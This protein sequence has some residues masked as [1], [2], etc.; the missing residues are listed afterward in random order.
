MIFSI[1]IILNKINGKSYIGFTNNINKRFREHKRLYKTSNFP[2]YRA[3]RKYTI[4]NFEFSIIYQSKDKEHTLCCMESYFIEKYNAFTEGY[5]CTLGGEGM[6]GHIPWNK[7]IKTGSQ[8]HETKQKK[9]ETQKKIISRMTPEIRKVKY[10]SKKEKNGMFGKTHSDIAK[11]KQRS[12]NIKYNYEV[13]LNSG[14]IL[15]T[16]NLKQ[17]CADNGYNVGGIH[18][19]ITG[20]CKR[21]KNIIKIIKSEIK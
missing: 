16:N 1:Y 12:V 8:S 17:F 6:S 20:K 3:M 15:Y 2:I 7:G 19:L 9:S 11:E 13:F 4:E 10:G 14:E 5:N 18:Y 21:H